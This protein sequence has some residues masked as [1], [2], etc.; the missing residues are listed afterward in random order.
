M[1]PKLIV[2]LL[3]LLASILVLPSTILAQA[4]K[5]NILVMWGDDIGITDVSAYSDDGLIGFGTPNIDR[6]REKEKAKEGSN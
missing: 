6:V 1:K 2:I 4:K 5:P 3:T